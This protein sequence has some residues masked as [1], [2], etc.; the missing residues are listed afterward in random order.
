M[1]QSKNSDNLHTCA[2]VAECPIND[3]DTLQNVKNRARAAD[4][5][6]FS[7]SE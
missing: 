6:I 5:G 3:A 2:G 4:G 7:A 1:N